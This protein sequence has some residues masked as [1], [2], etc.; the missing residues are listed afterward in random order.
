MNQFVFD[1]EVYP[2][3]TLFALRRI[4]GK[5]LRTFEMHDA[6]LSKEDA[7]TLKRFLT[8]NTIITFNGMHYD[9]PVTNF[10]LSGANCRQLHIL[11]KKIIEENKKGWEIYE[12]FNI[13]PID[14]DH[15]DLKEPAPGVQVSL[16]LYGARLNT[17]TLQDLPFDPHEKVTEAQKRELVKYCTNDLQL[18]TELYYGI[19]DRI[20]LRISM[21]EQYGIDLRSKS[22]AQIAEAVISS[23]LAKMGIKATTPQISSST[24]LR[25]KAPDYVQFKSKQL[26]DI[27][28]MVNTLQFTLDKGGSV[29]LPKVLTDQDIA[30]GQSKYQFGIGG[31]HSKE[32]SMVVVSNDTHTMMNAD[33]ASYYPRIILANKLAPKHLGKPFLTIYENIVNTRLAAK[34]RGDKLVAESL[35]ITINGSFGKLGSRYSKLYS[36]D[37]M[38]AVTL[39]GQLTLLML[40]EA[41]EDAGI[42]VVSANTDGLEFYCPKGKERKAKRLIKRLESISGQEMEIGEYKGLYARDVNNYVAAYDGKVKAKGVYADPKAPE[43]FLKK[44]SQVEICFEAVREYL[45]SGTPIAKTIHSCKDMGKFASS[46]TVNGGA[47]FGTPITKTVP[48]FD[49]N[50]K[51]IMLKS[52]Q[53]E[54]KVVTGWSKDSYYLGKVVR[55]YYSTKGGSI[56]Y[57]TNGNLVPMTENCKPMMVLLDTVPRDLNYNW[58][59]GYALRMLFDLGVNLL[60]ENVT[61]KT[62]DKMND[63]EIGLTFV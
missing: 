41:F 12:Q 2:N 14:I 29:E 19:K 9:I 27:L 55:W 24:K 17:H 54:I 61:K 35:K 48:A 11:S 16:K 51:P 58:Y 62:L 30:I 4:D 10:A 36:P 57:K 34:A 43:N 45:N 42:L 38:L 60:G 15:I 63:D 23:E 53:K 56:H 25:Y 32:K 3:Y 31:L 22:D 44:N 28:E 20:D 33:F 13:N 40:I 5:R 46:R 21:S 49:D 50:G 7:R 1:I 18:T 59:I 8:R 37:L 52:K 39:T 26:N 47:M 6:P